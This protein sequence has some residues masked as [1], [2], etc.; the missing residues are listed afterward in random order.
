MAKYKRH[1]TKY[2]GIYY[3]EGRHPATG[4]VERTY[5]MRY[6]RDGHSIEE[7][8]GHQ[9]RDDM[10]PAKASKLR[11]LRIDGEQASN[12]KRR[13][14]AATKKSNIGELWEEFQ[15]AKK[16]NKS[17]REDYYRW[18]AHLEKAFADLSPAEL[19]TMDIDRLKNQLKAKNLA[20][21]TIKQ[22]LMQ[23]QRIL[24]FG[25]SRG[26]CD[27]IDQTRLKFDMPKVNNIKTETL[28][29]EQI[30]SLR[31]AIKEDTHPHA[32]N[33]ML[34]VL[35][36][37]M[38]RGELFALKWEHVDFERG[39]IHI[40]DPKG[41]LDQK[42]PLNEAA[43]HVLESHLQGTSPF[44]F[45]GRNGQ[46]RKDIRHQVARIK[47]RAGLPKDFRPLHGLRHVF[48][49]TL[50]SSGKVDMYTLSKLLTHKSPEMTQRYAHLSDER[51]KQASNIG[52][53]LMDLIGR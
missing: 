51:L 19:S 7:K 39:F 49:S 13:E 22:V 40:V 3:I 8:A 44:V 17:I 30:K 41:G 10:T 37:G 47:K 18:R 28:T 26:F 38:R 35:Y 5:Y 36:T 21:A 14:I 4:K 29:P 15:K 6:R 27:Q 32:G 20:P 42:I 12:K 31:Q 52:S 25:A 46:Q 33:I 1:Q 24:N 34:M 2:P 48:A 50:A 11:A 53:D 43:R 45:P 23:L 16:D 9:F